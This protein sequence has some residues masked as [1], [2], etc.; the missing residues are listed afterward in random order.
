MTKAMTGSQPDA[1]TTVAAA[2][3]EKTAKN[4]PHTTT[5]PRQP[6]LIPS[7]PLQPNTAAINLTW[8]ASPLADGTPPVDPRTCQ[9]LKD[10]PTGKQA[11]GSPVDHA[12]AGVVA[13]CATACVAVIIFNLFMRA[14]GFG[15][16]L[17]L[18][19]H[20]GAIALFH[21]LIVRLMP[22]DNS[23]H[24]MLRTSTITVAVGTVAHYLGNALVVNW[25]CINCTGAPLPSPSARIIAI[26]WQHLFHNGLVE[27]TLAEL[28]TYYSGTLG[29]IPHT[30][31]LAATCGLAVAW[32]GIGY[33]LA[34]TARLSYHML[35]TKPQGLH[36]TRIDRQF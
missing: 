1:S 27:G 5:L 34:A 28:L 30:A 21:A 11:A 25:T 18:L 15:Y 35:G 13:A 6:D 20:L 8:T 7:G 19:G 31:W 12:T 29:S 17:S 10:E 32:F 14:A 16:G 9:T 22:L 36:A 3:S 4:T 33:F 26:D 24:H 2:V 23:I